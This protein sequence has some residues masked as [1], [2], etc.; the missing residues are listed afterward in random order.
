MNT[1]PE[2]EF[3]AIHE[4]LEAVIWRLFPHATPR[5]VD[6][7]LAAADAYALARQ[8]ITDKAVAAMRLRAATAEYFGTK[9]SAA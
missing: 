5:Q 8:R 9:R 4:Q 7:M 2:P 3:A 6:R 1:L